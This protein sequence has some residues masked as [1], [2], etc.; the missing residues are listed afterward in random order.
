MVSSNTLSQKCIHL[1]WRALEKQPGRKI[2][3]TVTLEGRE[4][5]V[6]CYFKKSHLQKYVTKKRVNSCG[7]TRDEATCFPYLKAVPTINLDSSF[8]SLLLCST[9]DLNE[10][11]KIKKKAKKASTSGRM[12][13]LFMLWLHGCFF[14]QQHWF[15]WSPAL[16]TDQFQVSGERLCPVYLKRWS[17]YI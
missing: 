3:F 2:L 9:K 15:K 7:Y 16:I 14:W 12:L 6:V 11:V 10:R 13:T 17:I 8:F 4:L 5:L 1:S